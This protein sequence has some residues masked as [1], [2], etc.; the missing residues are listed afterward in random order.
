MAD[1][2]IALL[3]TWRDELWRMGYGDSIHRRL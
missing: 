1:L 3:D 2:H